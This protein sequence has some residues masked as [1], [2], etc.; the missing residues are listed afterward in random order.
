MSIEQRLQN[1]PV[2]SGA[3]RLCDKILLPGFEGLSLYDLLKT[4]A[5]GIVK[6]TFSSR[7]GAIAFSFFMAIFPF[8]LFVLNLIPYVPIENFQDRF[9]DFIG[10]LMPAQTF[11]FFFPVIEDIAANPRGGLLSFVFILTLLVMANGVNS[12]FSGFEYSFHVNINRNFFRQYWVA[13]LVSIFL[14]L[15][16][17]FS[18]V[19]AVYSEYLISMLKQ[20]DY[21][22]DEVVWITAVRYFVFVLLVYMVVAVLYYFGVKDGRQSRFFSIGA[23]VTTLLFMLTTY[24]FGVYINNFSNYNELYGSIGALLI[25][26]LY[27]WLNSN[28]LLLGFELNASLRALK[29]KH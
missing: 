17:L 24:L 13:L 4:Y 7:A 22:S 25:M 23:L 3:M 26:M 5:V 28:L 16:L 6:G 29:N 14:A 15:L 9:L 2:V 21:I 19:V 10:E 8:L 20:E 11:D 1:T 27:I 12:I 18:V